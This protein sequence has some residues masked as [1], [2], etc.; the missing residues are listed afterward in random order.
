ML[1]VPS[2]Q[3]TRVLKLQSTCAQGSPLQTR[4]LRRTL[5]HES[6][7]VFIL[8]DK[9][10]F[11]PIRQDQMTIFRAMSIKRY[12]TSFQR[13]VKTLFQLNRPE[14]K[15]NFMASRYA[16]TSFQ[17]PS[18]CCPILSAIITVTV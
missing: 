7:M 1:S 8:S 15:V 9:D 13:D 17:A 18:T 3:Q 2:V 6:Q 4:D 12:F 10:S 11:D 14:C 5:A 16:H